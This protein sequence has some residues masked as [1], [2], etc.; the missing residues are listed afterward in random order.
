MMYWHIMPSCTELGFWCPGKSVPATMDTY[1]EG[2][3]IQD[4]MIFAAAAG[5]VA[6]GR[7]LQ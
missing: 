4:Q 5:K 6:R 2:I 1:F 7:S 3:R